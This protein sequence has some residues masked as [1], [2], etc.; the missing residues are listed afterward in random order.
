MNTSFTKSQTGKYVDVTYNTH[1]PNLFMNLRYNAHQ[2]CL[3]DEDAD[4]FIAK[5]QEME[6]TIAEEM[7][8]QNFSYKVELI[9]LTYMP[10]IESVSSG[11]DVRSKLSTQELA[12]LIVNGYNKKYVEAL[13]FCTDTIKMFDETGKAEGYPKN[14]KIYDRH[15]ELVEEFQFDLRK[16]KDSDFDVNLETLNQAASKML[17]ELIKLNESKNNS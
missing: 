15:N 9:I 7:A 1:I 16:I 10:L 17:D 3:S 13:S 5:V 12:K 11:F 2:S 6:K 8:K 4:K 14:Y